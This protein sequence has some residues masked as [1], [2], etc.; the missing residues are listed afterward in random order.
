MDALAASIYG[1]S[2]L[3]PLITKETG[4]RLQVITLAKVVKS[5]REGK[6]S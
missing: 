5:R 3:S 6:L 1:G 2:K 4:K